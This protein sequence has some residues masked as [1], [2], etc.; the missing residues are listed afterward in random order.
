MH[1]LALHLSLLE[2][3][4][5]LLHDRIR[6][7]DDSAWP[8]YRATLNT[9]TAVLAHAAP[10]NG[11]RL[12]STRELGELM[13]LS[14]KTLLRRKAKGQIQGAVQLEGGRAVKGKHGSAVRWDV[15][16]AV[17]GAGR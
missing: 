1:P 4:A 13:G 5:R 12:V 3:Q 11:G 10:G 16:A 2:T 9:L 7:G 15:R 14:S 6:G 17:S 8:D